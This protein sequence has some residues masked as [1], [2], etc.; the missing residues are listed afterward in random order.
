MIPTQEEYEEIRRKFTE[1]P[2]TCNKKQNVSCNDS[3]D[4]KYGSKCVWVIDKPNLPKTPAGFKR[5]L[6]LRKNFS[7]MDCYYVTPIGKKLRAP[8]EVATF[9]YEH[10]EYKDVSQADF[11]FRAPKIVRDAIFQNM[12]GKQGSSILVD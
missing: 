4:L 1:D 8:N 3:A 5:R 2:F 6:E 9:L 7:R 11:S 10:P 12:A